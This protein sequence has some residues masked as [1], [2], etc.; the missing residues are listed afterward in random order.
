MTDKTQHNPLRFGVLLLFIFIIAALRVLF[1]LDPAFAPFANLSAVGAMALFGGA[2]FKNVKAL[3]F[4]LL[5]ML[6][7]DIFIS[8]FAY[9]GGSWTFLYAGAGYV[10]GAIA[11]MVLVGYFLMRRKTMMNFLLSSVA[12]VFIHWIVTDLG[13]W[14]GSSLY[15]QNL[16]GFWACLVAAIPFERNFLLGTLLYGGVLFGA[17]EWMKMRFP[18]LRMA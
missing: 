17:F 16:S 14:I 15:P 8:R 1:S 4:P 9:W 18:Q 6:I 10:Y 7:S 11:L 13:V 2:Y 5:A 3:A 12:I